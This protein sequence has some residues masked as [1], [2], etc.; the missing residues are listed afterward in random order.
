MPDEL[1]IKIKKYIIYNF[2]LKVKR[3]VHKGL[4]ESY[5]A[6]FNKYL[7]KPVSKYVLI[8]LK[9]YEP[10]FKLKNIAHIYFESDIIDEPIDLHCTHSFIT[11]VYLWV[12]LLEYISL[13]LCLYF[14]KK[15][16][17]KKIGRINLKK[18]IDFDLIVFCLESNF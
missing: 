10:I 16:I 5:Y 15:K 4:E 6:F 11:G 8:F 1:K 2:V 13:I 7:R 9:F 3:P 17:F 14:L 18:K 12:F